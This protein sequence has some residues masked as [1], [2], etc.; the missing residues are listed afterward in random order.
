MFNVIVVDGNSFAVVPIHRGLDPGEAA[1]LVF[2]ETALQTGRVSISDDQKNYLVAIHS[3]DGDPS[4]TRVFDNALP[5]EKF[6]PD[7]YVGGGQD[8]KG[9]WDFSTD[10]P[11]PDDPDEPII[12]RHSGRISPLCQ[13]FPKEKK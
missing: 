10:N 8:P 7:T 11:V 12:D 13:S 3:A 2:A 9:G 5:L 4:G 1:S 6:D